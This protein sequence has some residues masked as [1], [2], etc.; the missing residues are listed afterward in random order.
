MIRLGIYD[1]GF[2]IISSFEDYIDVIS[3]KYELSSIKDFS[4]FKKIFFD[5]T[6]L[7]CDK[8]FGKAERRTLIEFFRNDSYRNLTSICAITRKDYYLYRFIRGESFEELFETENERS[9]LSKKYWLNKNCKDEVALLY[10]KHYY[11]TLEKKSLCGTTFSKQFWLDRG[12]SEIESKL[13]VSEIQRTN[14]LKYSKKYTKEERQ[15]F[16]TK[17]IAYWMKLGFSE[18]ES[19]KK[20]SISQNT[21]SKEKCIKKYGYELGIERWKQRQ[22]NWQ[23]TL[24][25]NPN[26]AEINAAKDSGSMTWA[27][28]VAN[29][30]ENLAIE[31][32]QENIAKKC[33][34]FVGASKQSLSFL[35]PIY[36]KLRK[37]SIMRNEIYWGISTSNEYYLNCHGKTVFYDFTVP[38]LNLIIEF[39]GI[40]FHPKSPEQ[41]WT[42]LMSGKS[43]KDVF[44]HDEM[45]KS[46]A[47]ASG[48]NN[49]F[50]VFSDEI[51][52]K[53]SEILC[54]IDT[55]QFNKPTN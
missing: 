23:K 54:Y 49:Y 29:G 1:K 8:I 42:Q 24:Q 45:K 18:E 46:L 27:L 6:K 32:Y 12:F 11:D 15:L 39:H 38:K 44:E 48:F 28:K 50:S 51:K 17:S 9:P 22:I 40:K 53:L 21:F 26:I 43:A 5:E 34:T 13:K 7:E 25:A 19:I 33:K 2:R 36:K 10:A 47:I 4:N 52:E 3:S 14:A 16:S 41:D 55:I 30:D 35:M 20:I 31:I 37:M